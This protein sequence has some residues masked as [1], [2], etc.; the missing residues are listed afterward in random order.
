MHIMLAYDHSRNARIALEGTMQL[1]AEAKPTITLISVIED[2]GSSTQAGDELFESQYQEQKQGAE[3]A[4]MELTEAGFS[5]K[6]L[7]AEGDA[8]KMILRATEQR[9]PD[10]LVIARHSHKPDGGFI[11]R[12]ID[13]LV[14]E[15]DH[16]T[17][18]AVS[19]FLARR[20]QCPLLIFPAP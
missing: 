7:F 1:F 9:Q 2:P 11:A 4:A 18:G 20:V 17:F 3:A 14:E 16:M 12:H 8:R 13:A 19:A 10:L 5:T 15:F 6:V